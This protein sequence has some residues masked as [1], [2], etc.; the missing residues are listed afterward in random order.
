MT[1][2]LGGYFFSVKYRHFFI[3]IYEKKYNFLVFQYR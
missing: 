2:C 1:Q 3:I